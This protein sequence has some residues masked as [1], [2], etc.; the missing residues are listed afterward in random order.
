ML[1]R[2]CCSLASATRRD[3]QVKNMKFEM[4][5]YLLFV[6]ALKKKVL[7]PSECLR[8]SGAV[9]EKSL[10][11]HNTSAFYSVLLLLQVGSR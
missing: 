7:W 9:I 6:L 11:G 1:N 4:D 2:S 10:Y 8:R 3:E 5:G